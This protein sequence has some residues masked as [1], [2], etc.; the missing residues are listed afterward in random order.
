[1]VLHVR[2]LFANAVAPILQ[3]LDATLLKH[4]RSAS[5]TLLFSIAPSASL[6]ADDLSQ[7][8]SYFQALKH[9]RVGA[10]FAPMTVVDRTG[11][12]STG[13]WCSVAIF[14]KQT[15]TAFRSNIPGRPDAQVGRWHAARK[16]EERQVHVPRAAE[17]PWSWNAPLY[18][19]PDSLQTLTYDLP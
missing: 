18:P 11:H 2:T 5:H 12:D 17:G 14:D 15:A 1:M 13:T 9:E 3:Q 6:P 10:L 19:L 4:A 16:T 8:V 7:L